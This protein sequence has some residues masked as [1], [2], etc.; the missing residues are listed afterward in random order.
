MSVSHFDTNIRELLNSVP[1]QRWIGRAADG[2]NILL[3][4]PRSP[5]LTPC[6]FF[7]WGFVKDSVYMPPFPTISQELRDP[8]THALQAI[9]AGIT[10]ALQAIT[11]G[12][13]HALQAITAGITHAL[14]AITAGIRTHCRPL[15][16]G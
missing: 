2:N 3:W 15:Q 13:T 14:Q 5:D 1:P 8:I 11:A 9:T 4:P 12:I 10:H 16:R 7:L 6:D